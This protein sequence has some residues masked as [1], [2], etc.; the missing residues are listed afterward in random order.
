[1]HFAI[2]H[3]RPDAALRL[4]YAKKSGLCQIF[5]RLDRLAERLM[6]V[7]MENGFPTSLAA[8][9]NPLF[10]GEKSV[11]HALA[12][13][14]GALPAG[15]PVFMIAWRLALV[16][17]KF[18]LDRL[19]VQFV[20]FSSRAFA[21]KTGVLVF[22]NG[23]FVPEERAVVSVFD[24]SFL[25][26][27]GLFETMRVFRGK[28]FRW[29]QHMERL[30]RGAVFLKIKLPH[31]SD[32]LLRFADE[33]IAK[34]NLPDAL[35]RLTLSR[36]VGVR[37]YS[38]K[39][40]DSSTVVM[41]LHPAPAFDANNPP[42]WKLIASS[43]RLPA[44]EALAQ[45]KTCNKLAQILARAEADAAGADEALLLNT[46]GF[47]VEG[48]S[49]N[50]FWIEGDSIFTPPL[51]A[52]ILPGVT[53]AVVLEICQQLGLR[54]SEA[55]INAKQLRCMDGVF[56]SLSSFGVIE[57]ASLDGVNVKASAISKQIRD[58]YAEL[59]ARND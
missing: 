12:R 14:Y 56:V 54:T 22:L 50:L 20:S 32:A 29:E 31:T 7:Q 34:N 51:A 47:V 3:L 43:H 18:G 17:G 26:G 6:G 58:R 19:F 55:N 59:V 48:A 36:G 1:M 2:F 49:S 45:F 21:L 33:L 23:Q 44:N 4:S 27:D 53:R 8:F 24:R 52:G 40:A 57:I 41:S 28:P 37:G 25:Y 5:K 35:L 11:R 9:G 30:Q 42:R 10:D 16:M 15:R 46:D 13:D 39:G 38:P